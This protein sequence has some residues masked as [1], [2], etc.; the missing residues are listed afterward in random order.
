MKKV[1]TYCDICGTE[2]TK[3]NVANAE[4]HFHFNK[5]VWEYTERNKCDKNDLCINCATAIENKL[6]QWCIQETELIR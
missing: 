2:L 3:E 5:W 4:L 6:H 1:T